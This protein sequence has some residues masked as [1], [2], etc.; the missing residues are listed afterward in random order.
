MDRLRQS[1]LIPFVL[2][3]TVSLS[4]CAQ[5]DNEVIIQTR[6][7]EVEVPADQ[8]RCGVI[9]PLPD[10]DDPE[11]SQEELALYLPELIKVAEECKYDL[12]TLNAIID[13]YNELVRELN[14]KAD[15]A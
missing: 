13:D 1:W 15:A 8:Q 7:N 6:P 12:I 3:V 5:P 10:P 11:T 4:A 9:P 2:C 14:A